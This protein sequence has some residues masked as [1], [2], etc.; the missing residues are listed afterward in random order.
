MRAAYSRRL[1]RALR[2]DWPEVTW[3]ADVD[4]FF[5]AARYLRAWALEA[6]LSRDLRRDLGP[7]WFA[8][9]AAGAR[10]RA[11]WAEGQPA[12]ASELLGREPDFA[13]LTEELT[14]RF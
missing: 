5:Y 9:P 4:P 13:A 7:E 1:S 6:E 14:A 8:E 10:I 3:L 12:T 2:L 11:L